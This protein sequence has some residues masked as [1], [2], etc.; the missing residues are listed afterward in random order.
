MKSRIA[1]SRVTA[2]A[3]QLLLI[4]LLF[5]V[6]ELLARNRLIDTF[7]YGQPTQ[8]AS[9]FAKHINDGSLLRATWVTLFETL[10]GFVLGMTMGVAGGLGL[11]WSRTVAAILEPFLVALQA[12]PKIIFA[13]IIILLIGFGIEFK[14]AVSFAGVVI[15]ALLSTYAGTK[16]TDPDLIDLL[17][18]IGASRWQVFT[19]VVVPTTLPWI[20][21]ASEINIGFALVGAVVAE[22]IASNEGLGYLA[23]YGA[24]TFDMSLVLVPVLTLVV[25]AAV[26]YGAVKFIEK[27]LPKNLQAS[28]ANWGA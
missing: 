17:R 13:P 28:A 2:V 7:Y 3:V 11:W 6:W 25:L 21:V 20:V 10:A 26:M 24:R 18:S 8:I 14:V 5:A 15:I 4:V 23:M 19:S 12:V 22:F 27:L 9:Y 1:G 16:E